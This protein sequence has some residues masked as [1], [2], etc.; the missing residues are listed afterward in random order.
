MKS[1]LVSV[2]L[3]SLLPFGHFPPLTQLYHRV[4][5]FR[6]TQ[7]II[8]GQSLLMLIVNSK[9]FRCGEVCIEWWMVKSTLKE[10]LSIP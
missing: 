9:E 7:G 4:P 2:T 8:H 6:V 3:E 10:V 5:F 1:W